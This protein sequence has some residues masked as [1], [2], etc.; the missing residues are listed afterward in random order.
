MLRSLAGTMAGDVERGLA[1]MGGV[2]PAARPGRPEEVAA[3]A[4]F[5][6]SDDAAFVHGVGWPVDGGALAVIQ[7]PT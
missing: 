1:F 6:C 2:A 3:I 5:L 4:T 7:N